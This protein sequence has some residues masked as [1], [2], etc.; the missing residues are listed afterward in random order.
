MPKL[1][2]KIGIFMFDKIG[3]KMQKFALLVRMVYIIGSNFKVILTH[4]LSK[5]TIVQ[6]IK[7]F[8][9]RGKGRNGLGSCHY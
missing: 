5:T 7:I 3:H 6:F 9:V 4:I 8:L 2:F 1:Y